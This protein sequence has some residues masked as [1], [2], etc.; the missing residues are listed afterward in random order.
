[1]SRRE[2]V[3]TSNNEDVAKLDG[4]RIIAY[5]RGE[6]PCRFAMRA[7]TA[8]PTSRSWVIAAGSRS[9]PMP[10]YNFI[11]QAVNAKLAQKK[12]QPSEDCTDADFVR[13]VYLDLTG[14]VPT[15]PAARAFVEDKTPSRDKRQKLVDELV[16][17]RDFVA[18]WSN[19]WADLLQC[20]SKTLGE[21]GVWTFREWIRQ[22][23]AQN[24]PYNQFVH[25][26][27][28]AEGS[29]RDESRRQLF[30]NPPRDRKDHRRREPDVPGRSIQLQQVPRSPFRALDAG[31]VL[32]IR[33]V[34]RPGG[35]QA[36]QSAPAKKSSSTTS[37][38]AKSFTPRPTRR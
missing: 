28:T 23:V 22:S 4:N 8:S 13:R 17:S 35:L 16:G 9:A 15:A 29:S 33:R 38:A 36:G 10:E 14:I 20:N 25:E 5:R 11:D 2:A 32:P 34:L 1:M 21:D 12:I 19:K 3:L 30:S 37:M 6:G 24:K 27:I 26:L 18:Y 31:A 7:T